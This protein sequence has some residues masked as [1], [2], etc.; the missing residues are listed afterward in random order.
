MAG[1]K[2]TVCESAARIESRPNSARMLLDDFLAAYLKAQQGLAAYLKAQQGGGGSLAVVQR[3]VPYVSIVAS[4]N[5][6]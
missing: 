5:E 1:D 2:L 4:A 6:S 3:C